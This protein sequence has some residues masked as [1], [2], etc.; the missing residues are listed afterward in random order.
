MKPASS[1]PEGC[2]S[3]FAID[4]RLAGELTGPE[5][6]TAR[7]HLEGC[8]RCERRVTE[9]AAGR[10]AFA[11]EAPPLRL[12]AG[13]EPRKARHFSV[14]A[15]ASSGLALAATIV[16]LVAFRPPKGALGTD[17]EGTRTK[18]DAEKLGFYVNH[19]GKVRRGG[20]GERVQPGDG[21]RFVA[22]AREARYLAVLSVD[23]LRHASTYYPSSA[24]NIRPL[25]GTAVAV[26][27]STTL[28]DTLGDETLYGI[29]CPES[30]L[31]EP[32][33][34]ALEESPDVPPAPKGCSVDVLHIH[35]DRAP[36]P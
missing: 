13:R 35:K 18:G 12:P 20:P 4:R 22:T 23:G 2:L 33:R 16:L 15:I 28:D 19:A 25:V 30:F 8:T 11:K 31:A 14:A 27:E 17:P 36:T 24:G 10:D 26:D 34:K 3:D 5:E 7:A 6:A 21:L 9:L 32:L 1:R 29:F